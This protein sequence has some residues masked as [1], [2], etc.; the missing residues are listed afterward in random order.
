MN[1]I[2]TFLAL[3]SVS[4]AFGV[5]AQVKPGATAVDVATYA[6]ADRMQKLVEG[7]K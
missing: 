7:A 5:C 4:L 1:T 3:A 6:G 2:R